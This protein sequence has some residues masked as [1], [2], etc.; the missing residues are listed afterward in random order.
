VRFHGRKEESTE[1][2]NDEEDPEKEVNRS[3]FLALIRRSEHAA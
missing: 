3:R 2:E 1:E